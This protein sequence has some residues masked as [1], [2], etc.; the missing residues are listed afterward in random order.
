M[1]IGARGQHQAVHGLDAPLPL[2]ELGGQPVE[3][4]GMRGMGAI[5]AEIAGRAHQPF[6]EVILPDPVHHH[7]RC[8]RVLGAGNPFC[9]RQ[10]AARAASGKRYLGRLRRSGDALQKTRFRLLSLAAQFP[11]DQQ[12]GGR[13]PWNVRRDQVLD[14]IGDRPVALQVL[15]QV[16]QLVFG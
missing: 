10:P 11:G 6:A 2:D 12:M 5:L 15:I 8:Q 4:L 1:L 9:Q 7:P 14:R 16:L 3:Q 13:N